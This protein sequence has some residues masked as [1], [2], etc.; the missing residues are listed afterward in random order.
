[1]AASGSHGF[2]RDGVRTLRASRKIPEPGGISGPLPAR[3]H[4]ARGVLEERRH[5]G[6]RLVHWR[7][8]SATLPNSSLMMAFQR[9]KVAAPLMKRPFTNELGVAASPSSA[10]AVASAFTASR[11]LPESRQLSN[12]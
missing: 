12:C 8:V 9:S 10:P 4:A 2:L 1:M 5:A 3:R 7:A 11:E 6:P